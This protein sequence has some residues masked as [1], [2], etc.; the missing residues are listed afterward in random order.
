MKRMILSL[1]LAGLLLITA[2][3][4][5]APSVSS[6]DMIGL[7]DAPVFSL[8]GVN[9]YLDESGNLYTWGYDRHNDNAQNSDLSSDISLGQGTEILY[10]AVPTRIANDIVQ[11]SYGRAVTQSGTLLEWSKLLQDDSCLPHRVQTQHDDL[12]AVY[13]NAFLTKTGDL[14]ALFPCQTENNYDLY[15]TEN[16]LLLQ[17][18]IQY[19][20]GHALRSD[21]TLWSFTADKT[22][23]LL[24]K[25]VFILDDVAEIICSNDETLLLLKTDDSLWTLGNNEYG[26]CG[27]GEHGDLDARTRDYIDEP[28]RVMEKVTAAW[29]DNGYRRFYA[30]DSAGNLYGW[31]VND[32]NLL[33]DPDYVPAEMGA[34][35][36]TQRQLVCQPRLLLDNVRDVS[37][38]PTCIFAIRTDDT[39]W[40]WGVADRGELGNGLYAHD[41]SGD[42]IELAH[43]LLEPDAL[44]CG[45]AKIL[46]NVE[47][48]L[49]STQVLYYAL[50]K[51]G[52]I[53]YWGC[54]VIPVGADD[55]PTTHLPASYGENAYFALEIIA[56]PRVFDLETFHR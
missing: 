51:D 35:G 22:T 24:S 13:T 53:L 10:S 16:T 46:D 47:R 15:G 3:C 7:S 43:Q 36:W 25:A 23:G 41:A 38:H 30:L 42:L 8:S 52:T 9:V 4:A 55:Q 45:P 2:G 39:L 17:N 33:S 5:K 34:H 31:G 29:G 19:E 27:N 20:G 18:V 40:S 56:A 1:L 11:V 14:Y 50:K 49:G 12:Y 21:G 48:M 37:A 44:L 6:A 26:L 54:D 32:Y 28:Y